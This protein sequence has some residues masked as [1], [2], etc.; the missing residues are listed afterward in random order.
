M[1]HSTDSIPAGTTAHPKIDPVTGEMAVFCYALEP[2]F[3]TW[4]IVGADGEVTRL[5]TPVTG[6]DRPVMIHDMAL[7][8]RFL[9]LVVAP[10]Y[11]DMAAAFSGGSML[12]WQPEDGTRVALIRRDGG[13]VRWADSEAFWTWHSANAYDDGDGPDAPVVLDYV[14]WARPGGIVRG[15]GPNPGGLVRAEID[16]ARGTMTRRELV[17]PGSMEFP[18]IDVRR[19][20]DRHRVIGVGTTSG[21]HTL[22]SGDHDVLM[23]LDT[24]DGTTTS[25]DADTLAVGEPTFVPR[26]GDADESHGW[27]VSFAINRADDT[28]W[29]LVIPASD[30]AS[31]PLA[32]VRIPTRVPLGLHGCWLPTEEEPADRP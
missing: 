7:T 9:V 30:P 24:R 25:W 4:A 18:R 6:V 2:P 11:F 14:Q 1:R 21:R 23:W 27:W 8:R 17:E 5:P 31:G 20:G 10:L 13:P 16:P 3:L 32:R 29:W 19:T 12:A 15:G 22:V 26:P 28:S